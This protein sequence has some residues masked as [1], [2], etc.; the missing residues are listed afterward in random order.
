V[1]ATYDPFSILNVE[2]GVSLEAARAS[3]R[4]LARQHHSDVAQEHERERATKMMAALNEAMADLEHDFEGWTRRFTAAVLQTD[5]PSA[6]VLSV[7]PRFVILSEANGFE[8]FVTVATP[9]GD[10]RQIGLRYREGLIVAERLRVG[11]RGVAN[12]RVRVS[13]KV[14]MLEQPERLEV[15]LVAPGHVAVNV[16]VAVEPFSGRTGGDVATG[17]DGAGSRWRRLWNWL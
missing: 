17:G 7:E 11:S 3:Y 6:G 10:G 4:K 1:E 9:S 16:T 12:F 13:P 5:A 14:R 15:E 8:A 2:P